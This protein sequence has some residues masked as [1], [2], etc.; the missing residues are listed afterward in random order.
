VLLAWPF[1]APVMVRPSALL[2]AA[3][4]LGA[5]LVAAAAF[6]LKDLCQGVDRR[7]RIGMRI[8]PPASLGADTTPLAQQQGATEQIGPDL[9]AVEAPF[10]AVR[11]DTDQR[12]RFREQW[13]L[14]RGWRGRSGLA[15]FGHKIPRSVSL[16]AESYQRKARNG[17]PE[18]QFV[19]HYY[20]YC[21]RP[22]NDGAERA[23][24]STS[25]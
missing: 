4:S 12:S 3:E 10:I 5:V 7:P 6:G 17:T 8:K 25:L 23:D 13:K 18:R 22:T 24:L 21:I 14:D 11:A 19:L 16:R 20:L 9:Q 2:S 15:T 1:G